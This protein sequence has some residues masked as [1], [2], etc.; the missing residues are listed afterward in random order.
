[1]KLGKI[2]MTRGIAARMDNWQFKLGVENALKS[3][4]AHNWGLVSEESKEMN[5]KA[6][7]SKDSIMGVYEIMGGSET[8]WIM[9]DPG[10]EVTTILFPDEY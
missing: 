2:V 3:Y 9:T 6:L 7:Y 10:H 8:I 5:K 4:V 1:M